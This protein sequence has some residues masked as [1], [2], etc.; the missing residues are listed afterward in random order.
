MKFIFIYFFSIFFL[1]SCSQKNENLITEIQGD[2]IEEQMRL[3]YNDGLNALEK[4]DVLYAAKKFNEAEM[5][6]PQSEW[7]PRSSLMAAYSYWSQQYYRQSIEELKRFLTLYKNHP[8]SNYAHYLLGI[9]YYDS[10]INEKNDLR[11]LIES[12]KYF[13]I[14]VDE[15]PNSDYALD[16][17]YKLELIEDLMAAK[18]MYIAR[19]YIKKQ[20]W[21][22]A[23]N[24]LKKVIRDYST[25]IFVEEALFRI[26]EI[27]Y[28]I[29][30][31]NE[32]KKY[33]SVLG[34]NYQSS[35]WYKKSYQIFN[36]N[37]ETLQLQ[38]DN[39]DQ[40]DTLLDKI[41]IFFK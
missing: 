34:Y 4:G 20:K 2:S 25:T 41:K 3:A 7:A 39:F 27:Y 6:Y 22:A 5:L 21:I 28:I 36:K 19:H 13:T 9:N 32:A 30:L 40:K 17:K 24:R 16:A 18:E 1:F 14:L 10:I 11:P 26:T 29:G 38:K 23:I 35:E 37:Y 8:N 33:A 15:F 31:D 12:K